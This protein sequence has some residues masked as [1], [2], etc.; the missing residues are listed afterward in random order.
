MLPGACTYSPGRARGRAACPRYSGA[1]AGRSTTWTSPTSA[2]AQARAT[3]LR[4]TSGWTPG[5]GPP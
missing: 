4:A 5:S 3:S 1:S 2:L